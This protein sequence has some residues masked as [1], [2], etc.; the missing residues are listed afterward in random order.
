MWDHDQRV[1][2]FHAWLLPWGCHTL[3]TGSVCAHMYRVSVCLC[4]RVSV[5]VLVYFWTYALHLCR[6]TVW[7][8]CAACCPSSTLM[9]LISSTVSGSRSSF[10]L[11]MH[12]TPHK[13]L[14]FLLAINKLFQLSLPFKYRYSH[15]KSSASWLLNRIERMFNMLWQSVKPITLS[16]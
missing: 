15:S 16:Q 10:M 2:L 7:M 1:L 12:H 14:I 3:L 4:V 6:S 9:F 13:H 8:T 11:G 5:G